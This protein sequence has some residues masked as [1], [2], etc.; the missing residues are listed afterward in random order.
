MNLRNILLFLL[1]LFFVGPLFLS[2][3]GGKYGE[4]LPLPILIKDVKEGKVEQ[5]KVSGDK[6]VVHYKDGVQK[7]AMKEGGV[8]FGEVLK[9]SGVDPSTVPYVVEDQLLSRFWVDILGILLPLG[10]MAIFFLF[11]FRQARGAQD[12]LFSFGKSGAKQFA[13]GKQ[14]VTFRDVAGV[15]EAKQ[16]LEEVVDFLKNSAKYRAIGARTPKGVILFGPA[17]VGKTLLARAVAGEAGVPFFSMAGSEFMEML[18]GVGAS[19]VRDLFAT[20]K[21]AAPA[22]IF[23][24]EVD[25]IGRQRGYGIAGGH[26]EREQ[27]LNQILVEMDGF[28]PNDNVVVIA[29][30]N[31]GDL[32]DPALL[33]PGRFDRRVTLDLPDKEGRLAILKIHA[34]GKKFGE[35]ILWERV[36][37]RT[38]GFSGAD[39][40]NMLNE[41][42][43]LA[44]REDR[45][46]V[47]TRD[48]NEA[49]TKVKLGPARKRLQ[50]EDDKKITAYHEAGHALVNHAMPNLDPVDRISIVA[51]NESLGQTYA[52]P[53]VDRVHE[54]KTRILQAITMML[55]GR[56]AEELV[57]DEMTTGASNDIDRATDL[58][59]R[60]VIDFGMS[61]LG[62]I[63]WGP[64]YDTDS[65]GR[66]RS[67]DPVSVSQTVQDKVDVEIG[68]IISGCYKDA[69]RIVKNERKMMDR[70]VDALM[71]KETLDREEFEG[72][73]GKKPQI[74]K[75][76]SRA[77]F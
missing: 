2:M 9:D 55:G 33:R 37:S 75:K 73:V 68:K 52:P 28:T 31:R 5:I 38:V 39:L 23:I 10:V 4:S 14:D 53:E 76:A 66:P 21:R 40:E 51:R 6:L 71:V 20:A 60:M 32:L 65:M 63:N 64:Y 57:F 45:K 16:E 58:A 15:D 25:A 41:A 72:I 56:V 67:M 17:G 46:E 36:A 62:P 77:R 43:I 11:I 30:T 29:A 7:M 18:V 42:A 12:N 49:A 61:A 44:A 50:S 22:I 19:R 59:R 70:V 8:S 24:D 47:E 48:I 69:Q 13:K 54:T 3:L 26:D 74:K 27:T 34:R 1:I 35:G